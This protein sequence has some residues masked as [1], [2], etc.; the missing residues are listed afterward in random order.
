[1]HGRPLSVAPTLA[2]ATA[3]NHAVAN[4]NP[5]RHAASAVQAQACAEGGDSRSGGGRGAAGGDGA[6]VNDGDSGDD[7]DSGSEGGTG[8]A[9]PTMA[10][11]Q[12]RRLEVGA[13][14]RWKSGFWVAA[15]PGTAQ[16]GPASS[17]RPAWF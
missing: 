7:S 5:A 11:P 15:Q 8:L 10:F 9:P 13:P 14:A 16:H 3:A 6:L 2:T 4:S 1:M 17:D 12:L